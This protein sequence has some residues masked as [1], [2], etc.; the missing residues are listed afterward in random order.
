[1]SRQMS[2]IS[3]KFCSRFLKSIFSHAAGANLPVSLYKKA[4]P[5]KSKPA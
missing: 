5:E 3:S 2:T 4:G 1:M